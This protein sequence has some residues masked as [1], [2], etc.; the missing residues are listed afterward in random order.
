MASRQASTTASS[1]RPPPSEPRREPSARTSILSP[2]AVWPPG[3][4]AMT[5]AVTTVRPPA[6]AASTSR[7]M[8]AITSLMAA[9]SHRYA[10]TSI[11]GATKKGHRQPSAQLALLRRGDGEVPFVLFGD[12]L[13]HGQVGV[14]GGRARMPG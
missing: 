3:G 12:A 2:T 11:A 10:D 6:V 8:L 1:S 9:L 7:A 13:E 14:L 5:Q 4:A